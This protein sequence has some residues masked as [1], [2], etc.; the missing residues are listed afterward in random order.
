MG[1][2]LVAATGAAV[3][4]APALLPVGTLVGFVGMVADSVLGSV[5]QG[6]FRCPACDVASEWRVHR[7]G[8]R[9]VRLGGMAWLDNDGV[10]LAASALGA[11]LAGVAWRCWFR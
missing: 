1:A 6:R 5:W 7:C 8:A 4:G 9:T 11:A 3:G 10:N 2:L